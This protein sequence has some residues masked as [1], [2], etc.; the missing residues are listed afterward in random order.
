M[1][2]LLSSQIEIFTSSPLTL[3]IIFIIFVLLLI[4][5]ITAIINAIWGPKL[6]NP[7]A[8]SS[9]PK[10]S[11]LVP[12]RNES[13]NIAE[14]IESLANQDYPNY[15]VLILDDNSEDKTYETAQSTAEKYQN[16]SVIKG[17][18]LPQGWLGKNYACYQLSQKAT[19]EIFIFTDAD[20]RHS[21]NAV[22]NTVAFL[23]H[24]K[25][26]ML[27]AFPQQITNTFFEKLLVVIMDVIV[28]SGLIFWTTKLFKSSAFSAANGQW[29]AIRENVYA[30]IG[31]HKAVKSEI[32]EDVAIARLTK[33]MGFTML[34]TAGT[35]I[36]FG[37]MYSSFSEIWNGY[38]KNTYGLTGNNTIVFL[39][40]I[41]ISFLV[42]FVPYALLMTELFL[43]GL[44]LIAMIIT[45]RLVLSLALKH[46]ILISIILH[47][48]AILIFI[49]IAINSFAIS[50]TSQHSWK[51]RN[52]KI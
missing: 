42:N 5:N 45:W 37:K 10:V 20:N 38:S 28:Y 51:G 21:K 39:L 3:I 30:N 43:I 41:F 22:R 32:V 52:I 13:H 2:D 50:K 46:N 23:E 18:E 35:S 34:L 48:I 29:I 25:L 49:A 24:Y 47:P 6:K 44:L 1:L 31:G 11:I 9:S 19:G 33:K 27:S 4:I 36:V 12:A 17:E 40:I 26:D 7:P 8:N 15:E 14:S 16:V